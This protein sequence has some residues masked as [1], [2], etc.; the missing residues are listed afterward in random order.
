MHL[1]QYTYSRSPSFHLHGHTFWVVR[2]AGNDT[3]KYVFLVDCPVF[4]AERESSWDNPVVRDV[5]NT[6]SSAGDN[7][8]IRFTTDNP[9]KL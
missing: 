5:V 4:Q 9:G 6:G 2:S 1:R 3:Y 7:V 8:T